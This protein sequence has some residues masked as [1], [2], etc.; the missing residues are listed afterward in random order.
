MGV[1]GQMKISFRI[2]LL[3]AK[4]SVVKMKPRYPLQYWSML[5]AFLLACFRP[6]HADLKQAVYET[7]K[8]RLTVTVNKIESLI[9]S[10][11]TVNFPALIRFKNRWLLCYGRGRH[12]GPDG[13]TRHIASS[14]DQGNT[15]HEI[16]P[17][18]PYFWDD[19]RRRLGTSGVYGFLRDGTMLYAFPFPNEANPNME[20]WRNHPQGYHGS[21][22]VKDPTWELRHYDTGGNLVDTSTMRLV[23]V[24]WGEASYEIYGS[25]VELGNGNLIAPFQTHVIHPATVPFYR[26]QT[27]QT[28]A[29]RARVPGGHRRFCTVIAR[30]TDGG[31]TFNYVAHLGPEIDGQV[32]GI[33]GLGEPD[34]I[35]LA[36]GE[37]LCIM[38]SGSDTPMYQSHSTDDGKTWSAPVSTGWPGVK[39]RLRLLKSGVLACSAG[40]GAYGH[41]QVTHAMFSPDGTGRKWET[42][43]EFHTGPGCSYTWNFEQ[44]GQLVVVYSH[45]SFGKPEGT[46]GLPFQSIKWVWLDVRR[47]TK[48]D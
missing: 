46:Y 21:E 11:V 39:P 41:P 26:R 34:L 42:P 10:E 6:V 45:S 30:S 15:W 31:R 32:A 37:L 48:S 2:P 13:E 23:G 40:R 22:R 20:I 19:G 33:A 8:H 38:R 4:R 36:N 9:T 24:P 17:P 35:Q 28:K 47:E 7:G 27:V 12:Y 1:A 14:N 44:D 5:A 25:I 43:F 16:K 18:S 29:G 3:S